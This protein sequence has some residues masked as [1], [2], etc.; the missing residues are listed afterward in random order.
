MKIIKFLLSNF[1]ILNF[2]LALLI[3][4]VIFSVWYSSN[5]SQS[6]SSISK[7]L[8]NQ[9]NT[10]S[11]V[12]QRESEQTKDKPKS[13]PPITSESD[14]LPQPSHQSSSQ[15]NKTVVTPD[16]QSVAVLP[17]KVPTYLGHFPYQETP[18]NRLINM[19]KYYHRTE[20]LDQEAAQAFNIMK[21]D[22][23][24]QGV[25]LVLISGFRKISTQQKLFNK[26]IQKRG[27]KEAAAKLSAPPGHSEHHTGYALDIGDGQQPQADLKYQFELTPAY[28]WL[29]QN[30]YRYGFEL[31]FPRNN[32]QGVSFEPW[33]WRYVGSA[34]ASQIFYFSRIK[35]MP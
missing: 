16:P 15:T 34:R 6:S 14:K 3:V 24:R 29:M 19:G 4:G 23:K 27:S 11:T 32:S 8:S 28:Y 10:P 12:S 7:K 18:Q 25:D 21:A 9:N 1:Q 30:A 17:K 26:Q 22:A 5:S 13:I 35:T 20:Y 33:H 31:S 2:L